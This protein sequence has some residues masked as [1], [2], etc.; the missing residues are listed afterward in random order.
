MKQRDSNIELLRII[1]MLF[2]MILHA[3]FESIG[4]PIASDIEARPFESICRL[5]TESLTII[6]VNVFILI[7]G[8]FGIKAKHERFFELIFQIVFFNI[9]ILLISS[10]FT[11]RSDIHLEF[12][13]LF[14]HPTQWF[15]LSYILLYIFA[16]ILN[17]FCKSVNKKTFQYILIAQFFIQITYGFITQQD[18]IKAGY[19]PITF[20]FLYL[21]A[22]YIRLYSTKITKLSPYLYFVSYSIFS[23]TT[24]VLS[25]IS[26]N[27]GYGGLRFYNY[28]SPF[29][30]AASISFMLIFTKIQ[31]KSKFINTISISVFAV[32]CLHC[33][34]F[35]FDE[36]TGII[37]KWW[38]T[39][40]KF[41]FIMR[42]CFFIFAIFIISILLDKIRI[43]IWNSTRIISIK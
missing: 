6:S 7:S 28:S 35:T 34:Y 38:N 43:F 8:W 31:I 42:T 5:G 13:F 40:D 21:L 36:Y 2:I 41:P 16:P 27:K 20:I 25:L 17:E 26:I 10:A 22:R 24:T 12:I 3:D 19:S 14:T 32:Y 33:N 39:L 4:V 9:I 29:T 30:I 15:I 37:S 11:K 23:I 1:S 18:F